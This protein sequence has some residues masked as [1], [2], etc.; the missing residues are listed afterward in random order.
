MKEV[1]T[2]NYL[3]LGFDK[4]GRRSILDYNR[5]NAPND[6]D[7]FFEIPT[8]YIELGMVRDSISQNL[9]KD[10]KVVSGMLADAVVTTEAIADLAI[11]SDKLADLAVEAAKL[12]NSSVTTTKIAN[13]AVG[14]AAIAAAAIGTAHIA[15]AAILNAHIAD[16]TISSAKINSLNADVINAGTIT[17][18]TLIANGG[19]GS[20]VWVENSGQIRFRDGGITKAYLYQSGGRLYIDADETITLTADDQI[21][22][23]SEHDTFISSKNDVLIN[24]EDEIRLSYNSDGS[25]GEDFYIQND[26]QVVIK[27][28]SGGAVYQNETQVQGDL[29]VTDDCVISDDLD[30]NGTKNFRIQH[31]LKKNSW[32]RHSAVESDKVLL[33]YQGRAKTKKG[34]VMITLPKYVEAI[35]KNIEYQLTAI[36]KNGIIWISK[37]FSNNKF[38][39]SSNI[40]EIDFSWTITGERNDK[41]MIDKPFEPEITKKKLEEIKKAKKGKESVV[42]KKRKTLKIP[43]KKTR[44]KI[45]TNIKK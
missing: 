11:N 32:L 39:V 30:V 1:N 3:E 22:L 6:F 7:A 15:N 41:R 33:T 40:P 16:A 20:D 19:S 17:G 23:W 13:A 35:N 38:E 2:P 34:K 4:H 25:G 9:L 27:C 5:F 21:T 44:R 45:I 43:D 29:E 26:N 14:S 18:R 37:E 12:A 42:M 24:A 31:P 36:G 28:T 8:Q 10:G